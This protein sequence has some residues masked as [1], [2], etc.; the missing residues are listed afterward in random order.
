LKARNV[1]KEESGLLLEFL[2]YDSETGLLYWKKSPGYRVQQG[3]VAGSAGRNGYS[4][5][6]LMGRKYKAHRVA[7]LLHTGS[8]PSNFIDHIDGNRLNNKFTNLRDV[9]RTTNSQNIRSATQRNKSSG[10]LGAYLD[11]K[12]RRW[13]SSI[14]TCGL[15]KHL[16]YFS[17]AEEAHAAYVHAKRFLH[18]GCT[19]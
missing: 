1:S 17:S 5:I 9:D 4:S 2:S 11:S 18:A 14:Q 7:W 19:I 13:M 8:W 3:A 6:I 15:Q 12:G 10:L 16:G